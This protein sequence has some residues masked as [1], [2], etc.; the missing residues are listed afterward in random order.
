[1]SDINAA[2]TGDPQIVRA[3][4]SALSRTPAGRPPAFGNAGYYFLALFGGAIL[5]FWPHYLS[6]LPSGGDWYTHIHA[7]VAVAW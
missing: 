7:V 5:A 6:R 1:M 2:I 3:L 4:A